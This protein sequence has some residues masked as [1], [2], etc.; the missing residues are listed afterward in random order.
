MRKV[1]VLLLSAIFLSGCASYKFH[2]GQAPYDKG[3]VVS[4]AERTIVEYTIGQN[5]TVPPEISLAKKRFAKRRHT[6]E[7]YYKQMGLIE[8][9]FKAAAIDPAF[10]FVKLIGGIFRLP[11]IAVA[12][13]KYE[14]NPVY[15]E[16]VKKLEEEKDLREESR[17]AKVKEKLDNY[18]QK[19]LVAEQPPV[20]APAVVPEPVKQAPS[21]KTEAVSNESSNAEAEAKAPVLK[22][23]QANLPA[24]DQAVSAELDKVQREQKMTQVMQG[25][26]ARETKT[27]KKER[28]VIS[29][30]PSAVISARPMKGFSPLTVHFSAAR[31]FSPHGKIVSYAWDFGDGD[32]SAKPRPVNTY[33][34]GSF[35]PQEF[36]VTLTVKDVK[37]NTA[38]TTAT[39]TVLNK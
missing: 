34:S 11:F 8:N 7:H 37:G 9:R 36:L 6:V 28:K 21:Q 22:G 39:I 15:R 5:N 29:G 24:D 25:L 10:M 14:H 23:E 27:P 20:Q 3:Y 32:T 26:P 19:T 13:Y 18:I 17:V 31:S 12:D 16:K 1:S 4:R 2:R 35:Q 38:T 33:Y 30:E